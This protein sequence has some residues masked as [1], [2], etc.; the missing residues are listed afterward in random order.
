MFVEVDDNGC[1][2]ITAKRLFELTECERVLNTLKAFGVEDC[3][4]DYGDAID[5]LRDD[6]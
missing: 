3:W 1:V 5:S 4:E 2:T 6:E